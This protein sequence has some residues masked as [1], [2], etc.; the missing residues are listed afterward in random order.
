MTIKFNR[1]SL[2]RIPQL[3]C[4]L[5]TLALYASPIAAQAQI[6]L[7]VGPAGESLSTGAEANAPVPTSTREGLPVFGAHLFQGAFKEL[8]FS[9]FNPEY[10][11][12]IGD[13]IQLM[14]WG[15]INQESELTVDPQGN[16]FIPEIGPVPVS[17]VRNA[18]LHTVIAERVKAVFSDTV[19]S[20]AVLRGKLIRQE[21]APPI[22][23]NSVGG[24]N[25]D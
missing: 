16:L 10:R 1:F 6:E 18:D 25:T 23:V 19:Q 12:A 4:L 22:K 8:S 20:Y 14:L 3:I 21:R 7:D 5:F 9:G 11:V 17:G 13:R 24:H 15:G 2:M